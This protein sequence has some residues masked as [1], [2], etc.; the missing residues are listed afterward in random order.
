MTAKIIKRTDDR[1]TI[2]LE[3]PIFDSML[4]SESKIQDCLNEAGILATQEVMKSYDTDGSPI[5]VGQS[6]YYK[7]ERSFHTYQCVYGSFKIERYIYQTAK[8]G[9][10]YCPMDERARIVNRSTPRFAKLLSSKYAELGAQR[11]AEDI[12]ESFNRKVSKLFV[13]NIAESV[14]T[15]LNLKEENWN[16][17]LP[18][19]EE[20][21]KTISVGLDG[22]MINMVD[23][24]YREAMVGTISFYNRC[25]ER[26]HSIYVGS[27]PEKGKES[28]L[29]KFERELNK[30]KILFPKAHCI[31]IADGAKC[32]W[33]FLDKHTH[34]QVLDFYHASEYVTDAS[35]ILMS[36]SKQEDRENWLEDQ[37]HKLKHNHTGPNAFLNLLK[38]ESAK[39]SSKNSVEELKSIIVYFQNNIRSKRM[40]YAEHIAQNHPIG[41]GVEA[42]AKTVVKARLC[43]SGMKWKSE[44]ADIVLT[45]RALKLSSGRWD[46]SWNK[47]DRYGYINA[48]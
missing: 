6:K 47:I 36:K 44:G 14:G 38:K 18:E 22:T 28:F 48:A 11:V 5:I 27:S 25:G 43:Q 33:T 4:Q 1:I 21:I 46:Q 17:V 19:F 9:R 13:Q 20:S 23:D 39:N 12:E 35:D 16:Y 30:A 24:G 42:A 45:L 40:N 15:F 26:M 29:K 3:I 31:G 8:G 2:Q 32:N 7:K 37:C 41:S 10:S 34:S